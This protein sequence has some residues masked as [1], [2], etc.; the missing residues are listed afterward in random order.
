MTTEDHRHGPDDEPRW[1]SI[2]PALTPCDDTERRYETLVN[3]LNAIFW[4]FDPC[5]MDTLYVSPQV[6]RILGYEPRQVL[7]TPNFWVDHIHPDDRDWVLQRCLESA[8]NGQEHAFEYRLLNAEG[9]VVWLRKNAVID[10]TAAGDK[11]IRSVMLDITE[12]REAQAAS[13]AKSM[14]LANMSHEIRTPMNAIIGMSELL[15][16]TSLDTLQRE[17]LEMLDESAHSLL[18]LLNDILDF[19]RIEAGEL[20]LEERSFDVDET[21]G[22]PLQMLASRAADKGLELS[23]EVD[24]AVP[25]R[26][27]GDPGRL[28]QVLI[29]LVTNAIKFTDEG[30]IGVHVGVDWRVDEQVCLHVS[31]RDTGSGIDPE[32]TEF[33]FGAFNQLDDSLTRR[34]EGTGLGLAI[35]RQLV[36]LMGGDIWVD[37]SPGVGS[38]FHFTADVGV[39]ASSH[40]IGQPVGRESLTGV[41][42]LIA[43]DHPATRTILARTVEQWGMR[44]T[45][46][47]TGAEVLEALRHARRLGDH[48][49]VA[50]I[51]GVMP[52]LSHQ[53]FLELLD[54]EE[55]GQGCAFVTTSTAHDYAR[56]VDGEHGEAHL[57]KPIKPTELFQVAVDALG[58]GDAQRVPRQ[59]RKLEEV[60]PLHVL[61][62]EDSPVNQKLAV[63]LLEKRGHSVVTARTGKEVLERLDEASGEFDLILMDI[64]MPEMDGVTATRKLREREKSAGTGVH[65]PVIALTAHAMKGDRSR[66]LAAGM[67]DYLAKPIKSADLYETLAKFGS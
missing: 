25:T 41:R 42:V 15:G 9:R 54:R 63:T 16:D 17:Y 45:L 5:S 6:D 49:C 43:D 40:L 3:S 13:R 52:D 36:S 31:V 19:S 24:G 26:L 2:Q 12:A 48:Y 51:D 30:E 38:T 10:V 47:A 44:P 28:R 57:T 59:E 67:D 35:S 65:I 64:Q 33:I 20:E 62:A 46:A 32:V 7:E 21:L 60:T 39:A 4:E 58:L 53:E 23:Y 34:C 29:N 27:V 50:L 8:E 66:F 22:T 14:F 11:I 18:R 55:L 61:L 56:S 37:S 1:S